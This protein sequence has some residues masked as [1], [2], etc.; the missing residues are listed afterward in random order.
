MEK[1]IKEH[2]V[3]VKEF[4]FTV[5]VLMEMRTEDLTKS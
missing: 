3:K 1:I 5:K 4:T 2:K